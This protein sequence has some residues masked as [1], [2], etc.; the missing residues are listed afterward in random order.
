MLDAILE[1]YPEQIE[2]KG[3]FKC[4][5]RPLETADEKDF[6]EFFLAVQIYQTPIRLRYALLCQCLTPCPSGARTQ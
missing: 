1:E 3:G 2:L 6:H 5:L 4:V